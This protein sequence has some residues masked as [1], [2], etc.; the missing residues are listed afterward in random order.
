[1]STS[2]ND[3]FTA[4]HNPDSMSLRPAPQTRRT[5]W[6][7]HRRMLLSKTGL[8]ILVLY[9]SVLNN[10]AETLDCIGAGT[11]TIILHIRYK[12]RNVG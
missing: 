2:D 7:C 1:M 3:C 12:R 9:T 10:T 4:I 8:E 6:E 5:T 11:L